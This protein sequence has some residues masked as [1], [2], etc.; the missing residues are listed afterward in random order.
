MVQIDW[1]AGNL[2]TQ[3]LQRRFDFSNSLWTDLWTNPPPTP[4]TNTYL[5][6]ISTNL[7]QIYRIQFSR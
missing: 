6:L 5:D 4:L 3:I 2:A 1:Q 7:L